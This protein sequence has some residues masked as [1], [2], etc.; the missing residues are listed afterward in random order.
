M[1]KF[2]FRLETLLRLKMAARDEKRAELAEVLHAEEQLKLQQAEV[3]Q[4]IQEQDQYVR[5]TIGSGRLNIDLITAS[6]RQVS[7][8]KAVRQEKQMLMKQLIPHI[9]QR[10]QALLDADHE[11]RTLEKLKEHKLEQHLQREAAQ[12]S[13][14]MDEIAI[15]GFRRKGV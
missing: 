12:E 1:A 9:Q 2:R 8:L 6:Q 14:Q 13:K 5:Q 3:E 7:F 10:R 11:V 4:E 15:N